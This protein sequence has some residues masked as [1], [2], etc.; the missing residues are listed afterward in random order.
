[1]CI[2]TLKTDVI[3]FLAQHFLHTYK[4]S[5]RAKRKLQHLTKEIPTT[6]VEDIVMRVDTLN[7]PDYY[8]EL[9]L[10]S[11]CIIYGYILFSFTIILF[12]LLLLIL[13]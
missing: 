10:M 6:L 11:L 9:D 1:M 8:N 7:G 2:C 12:L 5:D 3:Y 4:N 13:Y